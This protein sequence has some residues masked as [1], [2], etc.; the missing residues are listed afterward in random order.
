MGIVLSSSGGLTFSQK[1]SCGTDKTKQTALLKKLSA[2]SINQPILKK[3]REQGEQR[4]ADARKRRDEN[5]KIL[6][7]ETKSLK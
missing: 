2:L 7:K 1:K 5:E 6:A 4:K 3:V